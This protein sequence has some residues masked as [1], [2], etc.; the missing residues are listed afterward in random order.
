[1][2]NIAEA[3]S[4]K[5]I[6][7]VV[8]RRLFA[9]KSTCLSLLGAYAHWRD[10]Y[11]FNS[12]IKELYHGWTNNMAVR[13]ELFD[14][15]TPFIER[16]RG[17]DATF[18]SQTVENFSHD[19]VQYCPHAQVTHL[20]ISSLKDM[21]R[22]FFIYGR[23]QRLIGDDTSWRPLTTRERLTVFA[24]TVRAQNYSPIHAVLL[25]TVLAAGVMCWYVGWFSALVL[26]TKK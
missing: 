11:V 6:G 5:R 14:G 3:M 9:G 16:Q 8:G 21:F 25:F 1:L 23:S 4:D 26:R 2:R 10:E 17:S 24:R 12:Q 20:E 15:P 7:I 18:V 13:R 19:I 22:K